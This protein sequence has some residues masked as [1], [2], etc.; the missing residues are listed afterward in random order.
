MTP[1]HSPS[2]AEVEEIIRAV[3]RAR[4]TFR[5]IVRAKGSDVFKGAAN[6]RAW[7]LSATLEKLATLTRKTPGTDEEGKR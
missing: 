4:D 6:S 5:D 3:T 2:D 7:E 1:S